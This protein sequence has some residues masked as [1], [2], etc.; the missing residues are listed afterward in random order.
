MASP[1]RISI[2]ADA[3][4]AVKGLRTTSAEADR[5][6]GHIRQLEREVKKL[7]GQKAKVTID[8]TKF[9]SQAKAMQREINKLSRQ[10][11]KLTVRA[12]GTTQTVRQVKSVQREL[13]RLNNQ[14]AT[15]RFD[16][17]GFAQG[18]AQIIAANLALERIR[19]GLPD[20][21]FG[22]TGVARK[23]TLISAGA[24][25]AVAA[26]GPLTGALAA[27]GLATGAAAAGVALFGAAAAPTFMTVTQ[28]VKEYTTAQHALERAQAVGDVKA[29]ATAQ[30]NMASALGA[31]T[32]LERESAR[33]LIAMNTAW[34]EI[35]KS[36]APRVLGII[37]QAAATLS[38][39]IPILAPGID[40]MGKAISQISGEAFA[41][42][43][44]SAGPFVKFITQ[45]GAPAMKSLAAIAGNIFVTIGHF[46]QAFAPLGN[47]ILAK[48]VPLT[49][50]LK[51][52]N[53]DSLAKSATQLL[54]VV[55]SL[56]SNVGGAVL[57]LIKAVAPLAKP[58]L[59]GL[60]DIGGILKTALAGPEVKQFVANIAQLI[61]AVAPIVAV[62]VPTFLKFA[63]II[64][65]QVLALV[66][67]VLPLVKQLAD[68]FINVLTGLTPLLGPLLD[69]VGILVGFIPV[70][71][72][73]V[74]AFRDALIP[75]L[76]A[77]GQALTDMKP[78]IG[79]IVGAFVSLAKPISDILV[80]LVGLLPVLAQSLAPL[81]VA[82]AGI[83]GGVLTALTPLIPVI[84]QF[85][86]TLVSGLA[87]ILQVVVAA[88]PGFAAIIAQLAP[89]F[90]ALMVAL[91]PI[92]PVL[93][94]ILQALLIGLMPVFAA[95][96]ATILP[97][98]IDV[99]NQLVPPLLA[100]IPPLLELIP[101]IASL[102]VALIKALLPSFI[103][104]LPFVVLA[105]KVLGITLPFAVK[106]LIPLINALTWLF[107]QLKPPDFTPLVNSISGFVL[108]LA[109]LPERFWNIATS[110]MAGFLKGIL[111]GFDPIRSAF[112]TLTDKLTSWKGPPA[113]DARLLTPAGKSIMGGLID[114][115][116]SQVPAL[117]SQLSGVTSII[118]SGLT[119]TVGVSLAAS[120]KVRSAGVVPVAVDSTAAGS[121]TYQ[122]SVNVAPG[123]DAA[124][125]G[126]QTVAAIEAYER[127][128]GRR[129]LQVAL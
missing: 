85:I 11:A 110:I 101:P 26:I 76:G 51:T 122:I 12:A 32:P 45:Q 107:R 118:E 49:G 93:A 94:Q 104:L 57:N 67:K 100:L 20:L 30:K 23:F 79:I 129:R 17:K 68:V 18:T 115:I 61:P 46:A 27:V 78:S 109:R 70:L 10:N 95:L 112:R 7:S 116:Q 44:K 37:S 31:L 22:L 91:Q 14:K 113:R 111:S 9:A 87:P 43:E 123:A 29:A 117:K 121:S 50:A 65:G 102:A 40:A 35:S 2:L 52:I 77:L 106:L 120:G 4:K 72:P 99:T 28:A 86:T 59:Q 6:G 8:S 33:Q 75:V 84:V 19:K 64:S 105:A 13:A 128:T 48:L 15:V 92:F 83:I 81:F 90:A 114:G 36:Q 25:A 71:F 54:P 97:M 126:R 74:T 41:G 39:I 103:Q 24:L 63:E 1:I 55:S 56:L 88:L 16:A 62:V 125:V 3:A 119:P 53:F 124:E 42:L 108:W 89:Q 60:S 127:R 58:V 73:I 5:T 80:V 98:M 34:A 47:A 66:P 82:L 38:R 21:S 69:L 96:A